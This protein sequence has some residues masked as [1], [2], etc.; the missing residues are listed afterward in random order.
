MIS[1]NII[2]LCF[3]NCFHFDAEN[4]VQ[5]KSFSTC[6][7]HFLQ[8]FSTLEQLAEE[9]D[10]VAGFLPYYQEEE[11]NSGGQVS[12]EETIKLCY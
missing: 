2:F 1:Y 7:L 6:L 5:M 8:D 10:N 3:Q 11:H 9:E 4:D 12:A